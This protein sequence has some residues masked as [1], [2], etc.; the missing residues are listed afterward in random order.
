MKHG[1]MTNFSNVRSS[2]ETQGKVS[3]I[4]A[5]NMEQKMENYA[6]SMGEKEKLNQHL[7]STHTAREPWVEPL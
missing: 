4:T 2:V 6:Y 5:I 7:T 3:G 1:T